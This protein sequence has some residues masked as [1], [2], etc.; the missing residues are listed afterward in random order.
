MIFNLNNVKIAKTLNPAPIIETVVEVRFESTLPSQDVI[1]KLLMEFG[2]EYSIKDLPI[3]EIPPEFRDRDPQFRYVPVKQL[4]KDG[5]I[6]QIG[7]RVISV[8][9]KAPYVGWSVLKDRV[10]IMIEKL[11]SAEVVSQYKRIG[12]RYLNAIDSNIL[13][14]INITIESPLKKISDENVELKLG[15]LH[16]QYKVTIKLSNSLIKIVNEARIVGT[17][18]DIDVFTGEFKEDKLEDMVIGAHLLEK[19]IFFSLIKKD[20]IDQN[21]NPEWLV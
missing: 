8:V 21:F 15:F 1:Y 17:L 5:L 16:N 7:G 2:K 18:I 4:L 3:S 14:N 12:I 10:G 11:R 13:D 9:N 20:F 19:Q 6:F